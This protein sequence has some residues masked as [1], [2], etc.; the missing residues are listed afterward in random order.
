MVCE[1]SRDQL[2]EQGVG[3]SNPLSPTIENKT[4]SRQ[5]NRRRSQFGVDFEGGE[6]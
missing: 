3:G 1:K 5:R 2:R 4:I 6:N